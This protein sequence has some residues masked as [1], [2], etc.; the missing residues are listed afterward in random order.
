MQ[1]S[2]KETTWSYRIRIFAYLL[3]AWKLL[4]AIATYTMLPIFQKTRPAIDHGYSVEVCTLM[5]L[6]GASAAFLLIKNNRIIPLLLLF[7]TG[8]FLFTH[9]VY[10]DKA[11]VFSFFAAYFQFIAL[12]FMAWR[13]NIVLSGRKQT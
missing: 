8:T 12:S 1:M 5:L 4:G 3:L 11:N 7:M 9:Y 10:I 6:V 13:E 2:N